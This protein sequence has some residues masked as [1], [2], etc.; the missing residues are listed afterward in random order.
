MEQIQKVIAKESPIIIGINAIL[1]GYAYDYLFF[2]NEARYMYSQDVH[3]DVFANFPKLILS[4]IKTTADQKEQVINYDRVIKRGWPHF[5]N[6]VITGLR[7]M[8]ILHVRHI[9]IA[10]FDGFKHAYNESYGDSNLPTL[11]PGGKWDELNSEIKEIYRDFIA[12]AGE[13]IDI[14]FVTDSYFAE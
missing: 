11:N 10:G 14:Q 9:L 7:F 2:V 4:N 1:P 13:H 6:A 8:D 12:S 5:D 3:A